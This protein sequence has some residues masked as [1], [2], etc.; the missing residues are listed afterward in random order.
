MIKRRVLVV[1]ISVLLLL[2]FNSCKR[3]KL[4]V[5]HINYSDVGLT[6]DELPSTSDERVVFTCAAAFTAREL[7]QFSYSNINGVVVNKGKRYNSI[8]KRYGMFAFID[9]K[10]YFLEYPSKSLIDKAV[11][12]KGMLFQQLPI[13]I[14]GKTCEYRQR[15]NA[16]HQYRA[17]CEYKGKLVVVEA[18]RSMPYREFVKALEAMKVRNA[19]YLDVGYG[20][21]RAWYRNKSGG[22]EWIYWHH[23]SD[24]PTN[25]IT[26]YK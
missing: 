12:R 17:L 15:R 25:F 16:E 20:W 1:V 2:V 7:E 5:Y 6:F 13:I 10:H 3:G 22:V 18:T 4:T 21:D 19:M 24:Y 9:K 26:F 14:D 8:M 23:F 11:K